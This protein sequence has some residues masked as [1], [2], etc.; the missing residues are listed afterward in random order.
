M[1][2]SLNQVPNRKVR[3]FS[4]NLASHRFPESSERAAICINLFQSPWMR[5]EFFSGLSTIKSEHGTAQQT[6][7]KSSGHPKGKADGLRG[8]RDRFPTDITFS[9]VTGN[10]DVFIVQVFNAVRAVSN[11]K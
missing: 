4:K 11:K 8:A 10:H 1:I 3:I 6:H 5:E 7:S 2:C 9:A